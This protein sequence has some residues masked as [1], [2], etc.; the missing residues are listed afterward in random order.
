MFSRAANSSR[1]AAGPSANDN[2]TP[3]AE[4]EQS[5]GAALPDQA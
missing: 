2:H 1:A 4:P 3:P 5:H